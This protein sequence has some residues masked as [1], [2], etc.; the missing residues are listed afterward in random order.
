[1][2]VISLGVDPWVNVQRGVDGT[3]ASDHDSSAVIYVGRAD[4]FYSADPVGSPSESIPVS[5]YINAMNGSIW[6][7]QGDSLPAGRVYRWWQKVSTTYGQGALGV[8]TSTADP[9]SS[10]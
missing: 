10:T 2:S 1:M 6:Y 7:A 5:P 4:Q 9:S 3:S 8:R